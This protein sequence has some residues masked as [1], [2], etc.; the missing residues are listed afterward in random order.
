MCQKYLSA[1]DIFFGTQTKAAVA[2][3]MCEKIERKFY[4]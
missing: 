4:N 2:W 3:S 1:Y